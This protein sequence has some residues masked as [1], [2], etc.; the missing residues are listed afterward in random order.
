MS[1]PQGFRIFNAKL[2]RNDNNHDNH[3]DGNDGKG[4]VSGNGN[5]NNS[6]IGNSTFSL[7]EGTETIDLINNSTAP[8]MQLNVV[9]DKDFFHELPKLESDVE[10]ANEKLLKRAKN[11]GYSYKSK[12]VKLANHKAEDSIFKPGVEDIEIIGKPTEA[13]FQ[14]G[15]L[16]NEPKGNLLSFGMV[17]FAK[18]NGVFN[19]IRNNIHNDIQRLR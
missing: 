8:T 3:D 17:T 4:S 5:E 11:E 19:N 13:I 16:H 14:L 7:D 18:L 15:G 9:D 6:L 12:S 10:K 1:G 2:F